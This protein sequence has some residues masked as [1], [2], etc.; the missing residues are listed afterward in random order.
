MAFAQ[1]ERPGGKIM[2]GRPAG[3]STTLDPHIT[4]RA[5]TRKIL[6]QFT[7]T[8]TVIN[9]KD[10]KVPPGALAEVVGGRARRARKLHLQASQEREVPRR[11]ARFDARPPVKF[12]FSTASRSRWARRGVARAFLGPVRTAPM[13]SMPT[14]WA[15]PASESSPHAP[16]AAKWSGLSPLA[17]AVADGGVRKMG[18]DF[19]RKPV[20]HRRPVSW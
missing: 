16:V 3:T 19:S 15:R 7:D 12:T 9:P 13:S 8:L 11:D 18:E 4:N 6:I 1:P 5:A 10:G 14:P 2:F 20:G 17:P